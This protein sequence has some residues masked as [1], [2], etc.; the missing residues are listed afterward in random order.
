MARRQGY[1]N[2]DKTRLALLQAIAT[3]IVTW[4]PKLINELTDIVDRFGKT[5]FSNIQQILWWL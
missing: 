1:K 3:T 4:T 5:K 2:S